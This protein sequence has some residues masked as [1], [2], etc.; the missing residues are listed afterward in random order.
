MYGLQK[1][2]HPIYDTLAQVFYLGTG[3]AFLL[4]ATLGIADFIGTFN[5]TL[6]FVGTLIDTS[7]DVRTE[8]INL[9]LTAT[10]S[11]GIGGIL[12]EAMQIRKKPD[13][14]DFKDTQGEMKMR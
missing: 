9:L 8:T 7:V 12:M 2:K 1:E 10:F 5:I 14:D 4:L 11:S 3:V 6:P 13:E